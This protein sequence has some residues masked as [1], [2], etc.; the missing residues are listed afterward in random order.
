VLPDDFD[1]IFHPLFL[2][3]RG[4]GRQDLL[5]GLTDTRHDDC[6][7]VLSVRMLSRTVLM[8]WVSLAASVARL[9]SG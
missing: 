4:A 8:T 9:E 5:T 2:G 6:K 7:V 3:L 1:G